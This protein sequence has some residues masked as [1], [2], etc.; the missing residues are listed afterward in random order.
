MSCE[1]AAE[2][3]LEPGAPRF[4]IAQCGVM[5]LELAYTM[6][7]SG[8]LDDMPREPDEGSAGGSA[9][10]AAMGFFNFEGPNAFNADD[11]AVMKAWLAT[12][13]DLPDHCETPAPTP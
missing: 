10:A 7:R 6:A 12:G 13:T 11:L 8:R 1:D 3:P 5:R 4:T 9:Q 2:T